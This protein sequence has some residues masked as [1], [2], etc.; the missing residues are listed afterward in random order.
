MPD[1]VTFQ[2]Q[3]IADLSEDDKALA[4]PELRALAEVWAEQK[5]RLADPEPLKVFNERL[6]RQWAIETGVIERVYSLDRGITQLLI[7]RGIDASLIPHEATNKDPELVAQIIQDQ[8]EAIEGVFDFVAGRRPFGTSYIKE[9]HAVLTR[10]QDTT[11]GQDSLGR[12]VE[13]TL[14]RGEFKK[15][16]NN[17]TRTDGEVHEYSP[18]EQVASE[19]DRL[20]ALHETHELEGVAPEVE[21]A[22]VHHRFTQIHPFQ[23]GNGRVARALATL[24]LIKAGWFPLVVTR[25]DRV[26]Y[27]DALEEADGG[28]LEPLTSLF[29]SLER[30]AFVNALSIAGDVLRTQSVDQVIGALKD[31]FERRQEDLRRDWEQV[32]PSATELRQRAVQRFGAVA[33]KLDRELGP[34][35]HSHRFFVDES[36]PNDRRNRDQWFRVQV[37]ATA[38]SLGYFA[39]TRTSCSSSTIASHWTKYQDGLTDGLMRIWCVRL[40]Y[41][42]SPSSQSNE[43][44]CEIKCSVRSL[45]AIS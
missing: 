11:S 39:N 5:D 2:W 30:K 25:D 15:L 24:I 35:D 12:Q 19:I 44:R 3:P 14:L 9:L 28:R 13:V 31:V 34:F 7:E 4:S 18:P 43:R 16:P 45:L 32:K 23:D 38:K 22:W 20:I 10:H 1:R 36:G 27:I 21:A 29:V 42:G 17:P 33:E 26:R 41:G 37:I 6:Q 8:K 40:R